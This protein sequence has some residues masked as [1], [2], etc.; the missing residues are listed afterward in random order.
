MPRR[1]AASLIAGVLVIAFTP[2]VVAQDEEERMGDDPAYTQRVEVPEAGI[3][4]SYPPD[5]GVDARMEYGHTR[6]G[7]PYTGRWWVVRGSDGE[8]SC[9]V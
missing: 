1:I 4:V 7:D 5:W 6:P 2:A 8:D 9:S 3:A